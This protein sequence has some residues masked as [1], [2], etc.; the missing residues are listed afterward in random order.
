MIGCSPKLTN[1]GAE[2]RLMLIAIDN[3]VRFQKFF[4]TLLLLFYTKPESRS[5]SR[6]FGEQDEIFPALVD[7]QLL[8]PEEVISVLSQKEIQL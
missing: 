1:Q 6:A 5:R 4:F 2:Y 3:Y 8:D 7:H